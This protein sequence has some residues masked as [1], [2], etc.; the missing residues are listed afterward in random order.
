M[1]CCYILNVFPYGKI[2]EVNE[3]KLNFFSDKSIEKDIYEKMRV[4]ALLEVGAIDR[5][6]WTE[7]PSGI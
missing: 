6:Q 4:C 2:I 1:M 5:M 7:W 3:K